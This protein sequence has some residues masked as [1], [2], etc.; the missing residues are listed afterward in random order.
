M[1]FFCRVLGHTWV[2]KSENP[3]TRWATDGLL[4]VPTAASEPV[5]YEECARCKQ[6]REVQP[7]AKR[8]S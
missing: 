7:P 2:H 3:K 5:F 4:L 8:A 1:K 6:R